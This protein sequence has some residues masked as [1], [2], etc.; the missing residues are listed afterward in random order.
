MNNPN[1]NS[2]IK[3]WMPP[4][5]YQQLMSI[6]GYIQFLK[7]PYKT[8]LKRNLELKGLKRS[9]TA[10]LLATGPSINALNLKKLKGHDC[11]ALSNFFLHPDYEL[12]NPI[13][14]FFADVHPPLIE[15]NVIEWFKAAEQKIPRNVHLIHGT[16]NRRIISENHLFE[17]RNINYIYSN[18]QAQVQ[19]DITK[20][21]M[22]P[23]T[24]TLLLLPFLLYLGYKKIYLLG[25]DHNTFKNYGGDANNFY[26]K[27][28]DPRINAT[29]SGAWTEIIK[30]HD[31]SKNVFVQYRKYLEYIKY[32]NL[33][34]QIF[35]CSKESW[36][37]FFPFQDFETLDL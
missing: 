6:Y 31:A 2:L 21:I 33:D 20:Y 22:G 24:G 30:A 8:D 5:L 10:F 29:D 28:S 35:N 36:L 17:G 13:A 15:S 12:L 11:F 14:H 19:I 25:C 23:Q 34:T 16:E 32:Q 37:T 18:A 1:E 3:N 26:S 7:Y 4:I 27:E 9:D